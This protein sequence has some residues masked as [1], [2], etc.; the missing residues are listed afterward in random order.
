MSRKIEGFTVKVS[1][2]PHL[3]IGIYFGRCFGSQIWIMKTKADRWWILHPQLRIRV[4]FWSPAS[5]NVKCQA[6]LYSPTYHHIDTTTFTNTRNFELVILAFCNSQ[7]YSRMIS[8][9]LNRNLVSFEC[10]L[11]VVMRCT[12]FNLITRT[13]AQHMISLMWATSGKGSNC[14]LKAPPTLLSQG[15]LDGDSSIF[16]SLLYNLFMHWMDMRWAMLWKERHLW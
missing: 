14:N 13:Y 4:L 15:E 9:F 10:L 2:L 6:S 8:V 7:N 11:R 5:S 1:A 3:P 12:S 16:I